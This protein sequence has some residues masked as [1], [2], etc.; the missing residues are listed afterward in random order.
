MMKRHQLFEK[1]DP[2]INVIRHTSNRHGG[3]LGVLN[4]ILNGTY[5][6][7]NPVPSIEFQHFPVD[8][9]ATWM[10]PHDIKAVMKDKAGLENL[11]KNCCV[12]GCKVSEKL[13]KFENRLINRGKEPP[14]LVFTCT[15]CNTPYDAGMC[16]HPNNPPK[17]KLQSTAMGELQKGIHNLLLHLT[18]IAEL[19][20]MY[21]SDK[22]LYK[23]MLRQPPKGTELS[24]YLKS[25]ISD[26][27][28]YPH[29]VQLLIQVIA[30]CRRAAPKVAKRAVATL[31]LVMM[32]SPGNVLTMIT[33]PEALILVI[34]RYMAELGSRCCQAEC[35]VEEQFGLKELMDFTPLLYVAG[36]WKECRPYFE[37]LALR[38]GIIAINV[39]HT[40]ERD[41]GE[42][43]VPP[44]TEVH[45]S[46]V[47][48]IL[49]VDG[50]FGT[51][52]QKLLVK[53]PFS[54][55]AALMTEVLASWQE[56]GISVTNEVMNP[57][58]STVGSSYIEYRPQIKRLM[59]RVPELEYL[60]PLITALETNQK[61]DVMRDGVFLKAML[62][63]SSKCGFL[64]CNNSRAEGH[65]LSKCSGKCNKSVQYC[66]K[67]HQKADWAFHQILCKRIQ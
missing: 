30:H 35:I 16:S 41:D 6:E 55:G 57:D 64:S 32:P 45:P 50:M 47:N 25:C 44:D 63:N 33:T 49:Y 14:V 31:S 13:Q 11:V 65:K 27:N 8:H 37:G 39:I 51:K 26:R 20:R 15:S 43:D 28:N 22:V 10:E 52:F 18:V 38:L 36:T 24:D 60:K 17:R 19:L 40:A 54:L 48:A 23:I 1:S 66:S 21:D 56:Q 67:D 9:L 34:E 7:V 58:G 46:L 12:I 62:T 59:K 53:N 4:K 42:Y 61:P 29:T 2:F 5:H 3:L